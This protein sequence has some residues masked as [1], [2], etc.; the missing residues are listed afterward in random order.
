M[1]IPADI[2]DRTRQ[3]PSRVSRGRREPDRPGPR[4]AQAQSASPPFVG[5]LWPTGHGAEPHAEPPE[6]HDLHLDEIMTA[7]LAGRES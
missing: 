2:R 4:Q 1:S 5:V 3:V 7:V 6:F